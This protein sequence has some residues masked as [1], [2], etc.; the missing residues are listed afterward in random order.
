MNREEFNLT[1][2]GYIK[3][4]AEYEDLKRE[5]INNEKMIKE[6]GMHGDIDCQLLQNKDNLSAR[7][8]NI[9]KRMAKAK[10]INI[11]NLDDDQI[12]IGDKVALRMIYDFD[13]IEEDTFTLVGTDGDI[14]VNELSIN[15][16]IG[17]AIF[18]KRIGDK[19]PFLVNDNAY[20]VVI[21]EKLRENILKREK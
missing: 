21:L 19:V 7:M 1:E 5:Y 18:Q 10:I 17:R 4:R 13:E 12:N 9:T 2:D 6:T 14:S 15:S 16:P 3:L 20:Q 11:P 8:N